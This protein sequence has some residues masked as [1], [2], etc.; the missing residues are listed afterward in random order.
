MMIAGLTR[1]QWHSVLFLAAALIV[2]MI[3]DTLKAERVPSISP[4]SAYALMDSVLIVDVRDR[5]A[6]EKEHLPRAVSLPIEELPSRSHEF[7]TEKTIVVYCSEGN[8]RGPKATK[9]LNDAGYG[10]AVN[11][12]GGIESWRRAGLPTE[13]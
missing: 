1:H 9:Q 4:E 3:T 6:Y 2:F 11:L 12:E 5:D 10:K 8:K 13:R 7:A